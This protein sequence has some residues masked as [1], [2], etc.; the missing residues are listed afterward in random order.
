MITG[1]TGFVGSALTAGFLRL[2][3]CVI[4]LSRNDS[5]GKRTIH[6]VRDALDGFDARTPMSV[7][8]RLKVRPIDFDNLEQLRHLECFDHADIV[9]HVA[10]DMTYSSRK[11]QRAFKQN[12]TA[13]LDFYK[14]MKEVAPQCHRFF[15]VSTAY[16]GGFGQ[17]HI[18]EA[19]HLG[20]DMQNVYQASKWA[21]E[22]SLHR[23]ST[24]IG[25]PVTIFRP[26]IVVGHKR[27]GWHGKS[28]FGLYGFI[29]AAIKAYL[30]KQPSLRFDLDPEVH[31]NLITI[32]RLVDYALKLSIRNPTVK[33][34]IYNAAAKE[35]V[36]VGVLLRE[37]TS[38][39][40]IP[41]TAGPPQTIFDKVVDQMVKLNINFA[42]R[43]WT[44]DIS[45]LQKTLGDTF[46][47][48]VL[49][50]KNLKIIV[51]EFIRRKVRT[52][53][54]QLKRSQFSPEDVLRHEL[55]RARK[56]LEM[57]GLSV[58]TGSNASVTIGKPKVSIKSLLGEALKNSN[59]RSM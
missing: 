7:L 1:A 46:D 39:L 22:S 23:A 18:P 42:L 14:I 47:P 13:T 30:S 32:D 6:A 24:E 36:S 29:N 21:A 37:F 5:D 4:A 48:L 49:S 54:I 17:D 35:G 12:V 20:P 34:E 45:N 2:G 33:T 9:W 11:F 25:L 44:F 26:T 31:L 50:E 58:K 56:A 55:K 59:D 19:I 41:V 51:G 16:T 28:E 43:T 10:A 40:G 8:D 53:E 3:H 15:Y 52:H 27:T 38:Q 57:V